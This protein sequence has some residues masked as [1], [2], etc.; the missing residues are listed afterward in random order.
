MQLYR[1]LPSLTPAPQ[2]RARPPLSQRLSP[3]ALSA[4]LASIM[5][6]SPSVMLP[7]RP[8]LRTSPSCLNFGGLLCTGTSASA[9]TSTGT[10]CPIMAWEGGEAAASGSPGL[11]ATASTASRET[12]PQPV[13]PCLPSQRR[14]PGQQSGATLATS[15][16]FLRAARTKLAA[17]VQRRCRPTACSLLNP[18]PLLQRP[19]RPGREDIPRPLPARL[20]TAPEAARWACHPAFSTPLHHLLAVRVRLT[21][22]AL[23]KAAGH[24][25]GAILNSELD[26][27]LQTS[28]AGSAATPAGQST[29]T[30]F[31]TGRKLRQI[32]LFPGFGGGSGSST[33]GPDPWTL[34]PPPHA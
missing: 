28:P 18:A 27:R 7:A 29:T 13:P 21:L 26:C 33:V 15:R 32:S 14:P 23:R 9:F 10:S 20:P 16:T 31:Q 17:L 22:H 3:A 25:A 11:T 5:T 8:D 30:T 1:S 24:L 19:L 34:K 12:P 6:A 4:L 2:G